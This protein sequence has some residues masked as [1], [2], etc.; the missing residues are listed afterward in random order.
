MVMYPYCM[1]RCIALLDVLHGQLA[2]L[3][4]LHDAV[5]HRQVGLLDVLYGH[6]LNSQVALLDVLNVHILHGQVYCTAGCTIL[7]DVLYGK[8]TAW[9]DERWLDVL[10]DQMYFIARGIAWPMYS[11][12]R[13]IAWQ[14]VLYGH[15]VFLLS[16][17][18]YS[19]IY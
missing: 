9:T 17:A 19:Q 2:L 4:V 1:A 3:D 18:F 11:M 10:S 7:P 16:D 14:D 5:L 13:C 8:I 12:A 15:L 6:V